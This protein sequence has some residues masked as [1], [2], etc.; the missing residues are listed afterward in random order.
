MELTV[1]DSKVISRILNESLK[2]FIKE[3][4]VES[5][6]SMLDLYDERTS[7]MIHKLNSALVRSTY[8]LKIKDILERIGDELSSRVEVGLSIETMELKRG[9]EETLNV[10][11][12]NKFD[13][14]LVFDL[15]LEDRDNFLPIIY[16]KIDDGYFNSVSSESIIDTEDTKN[17]KF[18]IS[19]PETGPASTILFIVVRSKEIEGLNKISKLKI[20]FVK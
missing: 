3:E 11:I 8:A 7:S 9:N 1:K 13:V 15:T 5:M 19:A 12:T 16:N 10:S 20:S 4:D 17:F 14:P 18:R 2:R 6:F